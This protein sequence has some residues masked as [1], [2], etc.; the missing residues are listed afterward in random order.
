M[1]EEYEFFYNR[2]YA[3]KHNPH[4]MSLGRGGSL[5]SIRREMVQAV[6]N[7]G[8]ALAESCFWVLIDQNNTMAIEEHPRDT[9]YTEDELHQLWLDRALEMDDELYHFICIKKAPGPWWKNILKGN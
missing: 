7:A 3:H 2:I 4:L 1:K 8:M 6:S 5:N 9:P